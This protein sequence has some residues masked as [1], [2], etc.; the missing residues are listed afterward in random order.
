MSPSRL[1]TGARAEAVA[2]QY[3]EN[4][5]LRLVT[6]NYRCRAGE[7]DLVMEHGPELVIVEIRYR[8]SPTPVHP[9]ESI[10]R[11]KQRRILRAAESF[12]AVHGD[13]EER[14]LR[15]DV[16]TLT[17]PLEDA[18]ITWLRAAFSAGSQDG[19]G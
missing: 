18:S 16:V 8:R 1:A 12:L 9:A 14:G 2:S 5:G 6:R 3:L 10:T 17:G 15:F 7:L 4:R 13:Y 11:G 19:R